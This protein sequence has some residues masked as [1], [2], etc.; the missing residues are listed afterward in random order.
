MNIK[1]SNE[2]YKENP[3]K[4]VILRGLRIYCMYLGNKKIKV[5]D[6]YFFDSLNTCK[7]FWQFSKNANNF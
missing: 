2:K 4:N 3:A 5:T 6:F 7:A 1:I